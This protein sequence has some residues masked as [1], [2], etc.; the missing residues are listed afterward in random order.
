LSGL[1]RRSLS[2]LIPIALALL[3]APSS[4]RA[5]A[6]QPIN[7]PTC[8]A[9]VAENLVAA[10]KALQSDDKETR[11][12]LVCLMAATTSLDKRLSDD[13]AGHPASGTLHMPMRDITPQQY[14]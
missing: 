14:R 1:R 11:G 2:F 5:Q 12:A 10:Q 6:K 8:G 9:T 4:S 3:F 13:E 7:S